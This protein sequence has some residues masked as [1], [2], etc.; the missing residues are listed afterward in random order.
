M[1]T[2]NRCKIEKVES[3]FNKNSLSKDGL[4]HYCRECQ[5]NMGKVYSE[6][7]GDELKEKKKVWKLENTDK[8]KESRQKYY[9]K[10]SKKFSL[11]SSEKYRTDT[12]YRLKQLLRKRLR[13]ILRSKQI[14]KNV[15]A[16]DILGCSPLKLKEHLEKQFKDG[17][18]WDNQ[19]LWHID[20]KIP[21]ASGNTEELI[22]KLFHY[23]NLQP[24]WAIDNMKKGSKTPF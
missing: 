10:H 1:K 18:S 21:L 11:K 5:R 19:G 8:L 24:L 3:E 9:L 15:H 7:K 16:I 23:T 14:E 4:R 22:I 2:C 12:L 20:H 17:M 6:K 13:D